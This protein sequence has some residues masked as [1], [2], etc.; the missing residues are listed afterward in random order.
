MPKTLKELENAKRNVKRAAGQ[1]IQ[2]APIAQKIITSG[3]YYTVSEVW[4]S[5]DLVNKKV[6]RFRTMKLLNYQV[7]GRKMTR[8]YEGGKFY[9]GAL[10]PATK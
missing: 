4:K 6:S 8:L 2:F 7:L 1:K 10:E 3:Q 9:Y 5:P